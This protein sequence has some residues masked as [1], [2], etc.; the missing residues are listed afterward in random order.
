MV[1]AVRTSETSDDNYFTRQYIPEDNSEHHSDCPSMCPRMLFEP[2][3]RFLWNSVGRSCLCRGHR[4]RTCQPCSFNHS[5]M[6]FQTSEVGAKLAHK[7]TWHREILY[8]DRFS[9]DEQLSMRPFL[10][11]N[12]KYYRGRGWKIKLKFCCIE[13][14]HW[15]NEVWYSKI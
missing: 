7:P 6:H 15:T 13:T 1:E 5:K 9:K 11:N 2:N 3:G 4:L 14:S 8:T 10:K 12:Q